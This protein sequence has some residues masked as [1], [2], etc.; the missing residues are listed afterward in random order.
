MFQS[1]FRC[2]K[3]RRCNHL[4][5]EYAWRPSSW[6]EAIAEA[7]GL[8]YVYSG[9]VPGY[10]AQPHLQPACRHV[11]AAQVGFTASRFYIQSVCC[12]FCQRPIPGAGKINGVQ[13]GLADEVHEELQNV[14]AGSSGGHT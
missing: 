12:P 10:P 4:P 2:S 3:T 1:V 8:H 9:N 7:E 13:G 5:E 14:L 6:I 11:Q